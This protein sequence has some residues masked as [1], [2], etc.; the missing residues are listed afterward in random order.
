MWN[1][2]AYPGALC[3]KGVWFGTVIISK[4]Q[5]WNLQ[6]CVCFHWEEIFECFA[7]I[8]HF[9]YITFHIHFCISKIFNLLPSFQ[10]FPF[11]DYNSFWTPIFYGLKLLSFSNFLSNSVLW[12]SKAID[13]CLRACQNCLIV[14]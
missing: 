7:V 3:W 11:N 13:G 4:C 8:L 1:M 6:T 14:I 2:F 12:C 9:A 10:G 5:N